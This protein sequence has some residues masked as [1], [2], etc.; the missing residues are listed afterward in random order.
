MV[1]PRAKGFNPIPAVGVNKYHEHSDVDSGTEAQHHTLGR[2]AMQ[3]APGN[4]NHDEEYNHRTWTVVDTQGV[5]FFGD[6]VAR[7]TQIGTLV[8][9]RFFGGVFSTV[10]PTA[11]IAVN[12]PVVPNTSGLVAL[13][14]ACGT[15]VVHNPGVYRKS[16][17]MHWHNV[18]GQ[19]FV[20]WQLS[21][22]SN[23]FITATSIVPNMSG[24][25]LMSFNIVYD[26]AE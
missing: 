23:A 4:H 20:I 13:D 1:N 12:V 17:I 24:D 10:N 3:A 6:Y 25:E 16:C 11:Y 22:T 14:T 19:W 26:A 2:G 21:E 5:S 15:G 18:G 9:A 8:H 7:Y